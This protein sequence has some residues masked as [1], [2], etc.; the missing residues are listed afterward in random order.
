MLIVSLKCD[1]W[2]QRCRQ[3]GCCPRWLTRLRSL[4]SMSVRSTRLQSE[5]VHYPPQVIPP[6]TFQQQKC[7]PTCLRI[8]GSKE[9]LP[10]SAHW[11]I[12]FFLSSPF[13]QLPNGYALK[14]P[15]IKVKNCFAK[16][17]TIKKMLLNF[18]VILFYQSHFTRQ[19]D[20]QSVVTFIQNKLLQGHDSSATFLQQCKGRFRVGGGSCWIKNYWL[21]YFCGPRSPN[22]KVCTIDA[23]N[24]ITSF[25]I[26]F[27]VLIHQ[28]LSLGII[29]TA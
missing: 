15:M 22:L 29:V 23:P 7:L 18:I 24:L 14:S 1:I 11:I 20:V 4:V 28:N 2:L 17:Q 25:R 21:V 19:C 8:I 26:N 3:C 12:D 10:S 5:P 9:E 16:K 13:T 6:T 27:L